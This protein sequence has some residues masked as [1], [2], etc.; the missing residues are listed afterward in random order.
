LSRPILAVACLVLAPLPALRAQVPGPGGAAPT[1]PPADSA[2]RAEL[3]QLRE[4]DQRARD[5]FGP[6][7]AANDTVFLKQ[8]LQ[9][10]SARTR[11]LIEIVSQHGWPTRALVGREGT[12]AAWLLLQHSPSD[13]LR[14]A[15]L[16]ELWR[17]VER[18]DVQA[19]EAAMLT[20]KVRITAGQPQLYGSSFKL[21]DGRLRPHPIEDPAGLDA[22]RLEVGLPP[23]AEYARVLGEIYKLPVEWPPKPGGKQER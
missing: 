20:D 1:P 23:M 15:L 17:A 16:P 14:R 5:D 18:G 9:G 3:L 6:R 10:D 19:S 11:R 7:A 21:V 2:L 12:E 13:S 8:M 4:A 22:R